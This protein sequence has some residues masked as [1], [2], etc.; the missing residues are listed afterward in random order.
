[1]SL[2]NSLS[3][4]VVDDDPA[5]VRM[6]RLCL[7][8]DGYIVETAADG[9]QGLDRLEARRFDAIV[10]DLQMPNMD[11]RTFFREIRSRGNTTPVLLLS[12]YGAENAR[13]ELGAEAAIAKPFE[14]DVL[15]SAVR[16]LI[17]ELTST[18]P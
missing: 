2:D 17:E 15:T 4:L 3:V 5:L 11:G 6:V 9:L 8:S 13:E 10:L 16:Q 18:L 14:P 7:V 1:M 12:A